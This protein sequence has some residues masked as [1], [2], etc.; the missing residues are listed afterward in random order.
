MPD[1]QLVFINQ[2]AGYL[3]IDII[4]AASGHPNKILITGKLIERNKPLDSSV[5]IEKIIAY[6]RSTAI[7]RIFTWAWGFL[8]I[9][10]IVKTRYRKARLFIVTNPPLNN[11]LPLF[12]KNEFSFLVY[13]IYPD[14]LISF[15]YLKPASFV[16]RYWQ[17]INKKV[18]AKAS[19]I[20]TIGEKLKEKLQEYTSANKVKVIPVW[21]DNSF[22]KPIPRE[23]NTFI[24][25]NN[26]QGKFI[27]MYSGNLGA[28]HSVEVLLD[29]AEQSTDKEILFV[30][31]GGGEKFNDVSQS[32]VRKKLSNVLLLPWQDMAVFPYSLAAAHI[33]V[34][35][36][37][38]DAGKLSVP[39]KTFNLMSVGV[40]VLAIAEKDAE[41]NLLMDQHNF[42]MCFP[43][44][45]QAE[46]LQFISRVKNDRLYYCSLQ[47]N[48]LKASVAFG[49]EN[50]S[51]FIF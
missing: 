13:D 40:P 7:K 20:Y 37:S 50:A 36:I 42:G 35:T 3:M 17:R 39:S 31:I 51:K 18:F 26:L 22:L 29:L 4:H 44:K 16:S 38:G 46:M 47:E 41:L 33:G 23:Q 43:A 27:V 8:Q 9:V 15:N 48:S 28:T 25:Q 30:I 21:T 2:N 5:K 6:N 19:H 45:Q 32:I 12:C 10:W 11:F 24:E 1:E 34:V 14:A 49:V